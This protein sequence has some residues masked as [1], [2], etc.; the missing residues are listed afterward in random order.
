[1]Q[2]Q[3][4]QQ[5]AGPPAFALTPAYST[6]NQPLNY[7]EKRDAD[8]YYKGCTA[9]EGDPYDGTKLSD[10]LARLKAKADQFGWSDLLTIL[11]EGRD[12][13][14]DYGTIT[15]AQVRAHAQVY[16]PLNDRRAQNSNMLYNC[17]RTSIT[18]DVRTKVNLNPERFIIECRP[19][20][21]APIVRRYD[22]VC[23]VKAVIDDT[24][25]NTLS[26]TA[27]ARSNLSSLGKYM[28][29][30]PD[31][32][33]ETF[34]LYVK[35]NLQELAAANETTTDLLVNL[36]KG[37]REVKDKTFRTWI[38]NIN[39]QWLDRALVFQPDGLSLMERAENYYKDHLRQGLWL[40]LDE[41]Q[42]TIIALKAQL[43]TKRGRDG[44]KKKSLRKS[45]RFNVREEPKWKTQPPKKGEPHKKNATVNGTKATYFWC[46]HHE[47]WT[48]H[49]PQ[50]CRKKGEKNKPTDQKRGKATTPTTPPQKQDDT[51]DPTLKVMAAAIKEVDE[52]DGDLLF[53]PT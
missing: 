9:L 8:T 36:F 27:V 17:V 21:N 1:M 12:L 34:H 45:E 19:A 15:R 51:D 50:D 53:F 7:Q 43:T 25:T 6:Q 10:F 26:N 42:E 46:P 14:T 23:Y 33:I 20:P 24:Y 18:T 2:Q 41:D 5:P 52:H 37:Y 35:E 47:K 16:Q 3:Q 38:Q 48:I 44:G 29:E 49:K 39:D 30:L 32:N 13:L 31:S 40:K 22:G 4:Q 11:P 28:K